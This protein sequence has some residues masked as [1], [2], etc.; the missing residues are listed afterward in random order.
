MS[1][2]EKVGKSA[3]TLLNGGVLL[4]VAYLVVPLL[5]LR[6]GLPTGTSA[7]DMT[8]PEIRKAAM[9]GVRCSTLHVDRTPPGSQVIRIPCSSAMVGWYASSA[10]AFAFDS[11]GRIL[12]SA[13]PLQ[14]ALTKT[15]STSYRD[16]SGLLFNGF[17][18]IK[19]N[20]F[21]WFQI[22]WA[23]GRSWTSEWLWTERVPTSGL[24]GA[25]WGSEEP[26]ICGDVLVRNE[27]RQI[28]EGTRF[29]V[30]LL[31]SMNRPRL[32]CRRAL[33]RETVVGTYRETPERGE[34]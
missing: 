31:D 23:L 17:D 22:R 32:G 13:V 26:R 5:L 21:A 20:G 3:R 30:D 34:I 8:D 15:G 19:A 10:R 6:Q 28:L 33:Q 2:L 18:S 29:R 1:F 14:R 24:D 16:D 12:D 4:V 27:S 25:R 11:N 7:F 9:S